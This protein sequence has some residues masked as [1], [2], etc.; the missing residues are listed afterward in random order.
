MAGLEVAGRLV[1]HATPC[2]AMRECGSEA[3][4]QSCH[5]ASDGRYMCLRSAPFPPFPFP[6]SCPLTFF[7]IGPMLPVACRSWYRHADSAKLPSYFC[8]N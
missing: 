2:N 7:L 5:W 8:Q 4:D 6:T 3:L 1:V